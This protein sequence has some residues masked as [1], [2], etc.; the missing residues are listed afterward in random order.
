MYILSQEGLNMDLDRDA[1][2]LM[3]NLLEAESG[4][5]ASSDR[6]SY[7]RNRQKV[8]ELCEEIKAQGKGTHLNV[9]S[10]TVGTLAM[11][12]LLSLTSKRSGEWFKE[13]LR[14]LG[15]LEH[16][17]KTISD[18]CRP[19][20]EQ[21]NKAQNVKWT[22]SLI[23]NMQTVERCMRVLEKVTQ[24]NEENQ[25]YLLTYAQG[26]AVNTL[27]TLYTLCNRELVQHP[28]SDS[29]SKDSPTSVLLNLLIPVMKV[30][31]NLTHT[32]NT[33]NTLGAEVLGQK[34]DIIETSFHLLLQAQN[35]IPE[36]CVFEIS[37]LVS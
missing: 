28:G 19:A 30:L 9:D 6:A 26:E 13:E 34:S 31:I 24:M 21:C 15:G 10:I 25:K 8:R 4:V 16:I 5:A 11:E 33:T 22:H 18:C 1:L 7:E 17:I 36:R 23:E 12:T 35:Y 14:E 20:I 29:A 2:K 32:F 27:C 3:M 37:I